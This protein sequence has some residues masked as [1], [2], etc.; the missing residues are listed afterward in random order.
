MKRPTRDIRLYHTT[1]VDRAD[2]INKV[3]PEPLVGRCQLTLSD[4]GMLRRR[5]LVP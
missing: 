4:L 3:K 1:V 5:G 2:S